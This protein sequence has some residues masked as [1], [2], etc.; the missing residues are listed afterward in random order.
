MINLKEYGVVGDGETDD[1]IAIQAAIDAAS[2]S[3]DK[4]A[5]FP[6]GRY[7]IS[8]AID[9]KGV[10][11]LFGPQV[12]IEPEGLAPVPRQFVRSRRRA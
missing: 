7:R 2:A 6:A 11:F 9:D 5:H 1:T 8:S 10:T 12:S 4:R 3:D